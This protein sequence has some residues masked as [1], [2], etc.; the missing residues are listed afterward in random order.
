MIVTTVSNIKNKTNANQSQKMN[1][2]YEFNWTSECNQMR[3]TKYTN[4]VE[5]GDIITHMWVILRIKQVYIIIKR[6]NKI[7]ILVNILL[8][9][10]IHYISYICINIIK[11]IYM[12]IFFF[13]NNQKNIIYKYICSTTWLLKLC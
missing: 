6:I 11:Y 1:Q 10:G 7:M 8:L 5:F 9:Y 12:F 2:K 3:L 4:F 13:C